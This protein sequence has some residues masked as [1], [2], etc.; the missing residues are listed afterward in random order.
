[1]SDDKAQG[2]AGKDASNNAPD[3]GLVGQQVKWWRMP[4]D[5]TT[6]FSLIGWIFG[7]RYARDSAS[8]TDIVLK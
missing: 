8:K 4:F 7:N 2:N 5:A 3:E 1:M 6:N